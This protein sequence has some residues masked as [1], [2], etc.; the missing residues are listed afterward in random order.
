MALVAVT[1]K[2]YC[3][4]A[5]RSAAA[6]LQLVAALVH[7]APPGDAVAV[8]PVTGESPSVAG[9]LQPT[10]TSEVPPLAGE[11]WAVTPDGWLGGMPSTS[12]E[13]DGDDGYE[14]P[15]GLVATTVKV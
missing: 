4:P 3:W 5:L 12:I 13:A 11:A 2:V 9:G 8:Y 15:A 6:M 10:V 1:V 14:V 7:V